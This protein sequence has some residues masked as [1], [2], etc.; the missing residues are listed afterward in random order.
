MVEALMRRFDFGTNQQ[1]ANF[2]GV[3]P[4]TVGNWRSADNIT[5][6]IVAN[7]VEN[8]A[9][10]HAAN[11]L[12]HSDFLRRLQEICGTLHQEQNPDGQLAQGEFANRCGQFPTNMANYLNGNPEPGL[13]VLRNCLRSL[14]FRNLS[15]TLR[16]LF[17]VEEIEG[18]LEELPKSGGV[19]ILYDGA[20][21]GIYVGQAA[22]LKG[23]VNQTLDREDLKVSLRFPC[24]PSLEKRDVP[25]RCFA[26][27]LSAYGIEDENQRHNIEALLLRILINQLQNTKIGH[28]YSAMD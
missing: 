28:F 14:C 17:E 3:V 27:Y 10:A 8:A 7:I 13:V 26:K 18:A 9:G 1:L 15:W 5:P 20:V 12:N 24:G 25:L 11:Q 6:H 19:Y 23:E 21:K 16:P 22:D 2:L 4:A